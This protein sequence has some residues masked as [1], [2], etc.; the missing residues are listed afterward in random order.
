[1]S[2]AGFDHRRAARI[3]AMVGSHQDGEALNA[4]RL[5]DRMLRQAQMTW[6]DLLVPFA[7]M[8]LA[9]EAA[10]VLLDENLA[11]QAEVEQ[12][13]S[14]RTALPDWRQ[15]GSVMTD[16]QRAAH[17]VLDLHQQK[18]CWLGGFEKA[19]VTQCAT[20]VS[21]LPTGQQSI[22]WRIVERTAER[23]GMVP[24]Q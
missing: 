8:E 18:L 3:I 11:L 5:V 1:M 21:S 4:V 6:E 19:L 9:V 22:F 15:V 2:D 7:R 24:P 13:R 12:L 23:A 16:I 14:S 10:K 20:R 17:W